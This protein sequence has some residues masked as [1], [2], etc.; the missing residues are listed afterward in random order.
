MI[1]SLTSS[2]CLT[3]LL[4][5]LPHLRHPT[6]LLH[7]AGQCLTTTGQRLTDPKSIHRRPP[8]AAAKLSCACSSQSRHF[9]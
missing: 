3:A 6:M 9:G 8:P 4:W 5:R 1:V 2:L 7:S